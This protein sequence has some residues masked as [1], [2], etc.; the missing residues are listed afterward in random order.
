MRLCLAAENVS[1]IKWL[2][3]SGKKD[4]ERIDIKRN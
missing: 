3:I 4:S 2:L 1:A